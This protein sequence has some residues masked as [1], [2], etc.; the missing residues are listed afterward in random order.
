MGEGKSGI[1]AGIVCT[2]VARRARTGQTPPYLYDTACLMAKAEIGNTITTTF[3]AMDH[4]IHCD[5]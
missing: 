4:T 2:N 5:P 3:A 1:K